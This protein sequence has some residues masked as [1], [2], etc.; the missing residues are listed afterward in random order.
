MVDDA[1][2]D[3]RVALRLGFSARRLDLDTFAGRERRINAQRIMNVDDIISGCHWSA[4]HR[5]QARSAWPGTLGR[6]L[7]R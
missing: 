3:S 4:P 7:R 2:R 1:I 5:A 6:L